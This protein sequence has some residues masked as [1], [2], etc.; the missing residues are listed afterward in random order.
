MD[1]GRRVDTAERSKGYIPTLDGWRAIAILFVLLSHYGP[2][3][4]GSTRAV[5]RVGGYGV[6]IF[7][8]ISGLLI[9]TLLLREQEVWGRIDLRGFYLRRCLRILPVAWVFLVVVALLRGPAGVVASTKDL[10]SAAF[11]LRNYVGAESGAT[12]HFWSLAIEEHFYLI[13]PMFLAVYGW[14]RTRMFCLVVAFG[15]LGWRGYVMAHASGDPMLTFFRTD[16]RI[17]AL[18]DGVLAAIALRRERM[19]AWMLR[20]GPWGLLAI[21]MA[22]L[23]C[24]K[25]VGVETLSRS[26]VAAGIPLVLLAGVLFP[27]AIFA[28]AL[29]AAWLRWVGR[30]SYSLYIWQG[31]F[32]GNMTNMLGGRR[33]LVV[34]VI[35][36]LGTSIAS[37]YLLEQ[38]IIRW[39]RRLQQRRALKLASKGTLQPDGNDGLQAPGA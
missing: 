1:E 19:R 24:S 23:V 36:L 17:D 28:R 6:S 26:L 35:A 38:P 31:L 16:L 25:L 4:P 30:I 33:F 29:E 11:F 20:A 39:G 8:G 12:Q 7:F 2:F 22:G 13:L 14:R 18:F 10:W 3:L 32:T 34:N 21:G 27:G 5:E 37:Y 15:V 9:G